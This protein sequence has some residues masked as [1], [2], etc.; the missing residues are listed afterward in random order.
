M[1]PPLL[2]SETVYAVLCRKVN[3]S[4]SEYI[5]VRGGRRIGESYL[6]R[7]FKKYVRMAGLDE[8]LHW[9][10]LRHTHASWLVQCGVSLYE[11]QKLLGHSSSRVTEVYSH[12]QPEQ[13]HDTVN[14]IKLSF[15]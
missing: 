5:F 10:S 6:A 9:H 1:I 11:V 7:R 15:N 3:Q 8:G 2:M 12:L 14:R 4:S 13:L